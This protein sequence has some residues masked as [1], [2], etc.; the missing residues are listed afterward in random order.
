L[1]SPQEFKQIK[2]ADVSTI[3]DARPMAKQCSEGNILQ[4]L[5]PLSFRVSCAVC[6]AF[7]IV[8]HRGRPQR[9][10]SD[11]CRR[12]QAIEQKRA[13]RTRQLADRGRT[14]VRQGAAQ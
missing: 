10:C 7:D 4:P 1:I 5:L 2:S 6:G 9:F 3:S 13:W 14:G 11:P 8:R 12:S